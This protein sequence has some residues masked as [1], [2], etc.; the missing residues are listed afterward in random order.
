MVFCKVYC[1]PSFGRHDLFIHN[2]IVYVNNTI[3]FALTLTSSILLIPG[4]FF[5]CNESSI[6]W[7]YEPLEEFHIEHRFKHF[8]TQM[9]SFPTKSKKTSKNRQLWEL[10]LQ[11]ETHPKT[12]SKYTI[13]AVIQRFRLVNP[14]VNKPMP[15]YPAG[16][17]GNV[18]IFK[19][20]MAYISV[21]SRGW[22]WWWRIGLDVLVG[23]PYITR[24]GMTCRLSHRCVN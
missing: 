17:Y 4:D 12:F 19:F 9:R 5:Y 7:K 10:I 6:I 18:T 3:L 23:R 22:T 20:K 21:I 16:P 8:Y 11:T 1:K 13:E 24:D 14:W 15:K 2:Q